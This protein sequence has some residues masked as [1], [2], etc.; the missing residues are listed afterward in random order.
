MMS[1]ADVAHSQHKPRRISQVDLPEVGTLR[2]TL[3]TRRRIRHK[4]RGDWM[5]PSC[6]VYRLA[7]MGERH[8]PEEMEV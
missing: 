7:C 6:Q 2:A 5:R 8:L 1:V 3:E 4:G